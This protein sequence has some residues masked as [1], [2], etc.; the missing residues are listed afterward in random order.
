M[1]IPQ[2]KYLSEWEEK[3]IMHAPVPAVLFAESISED[4]NSNLWYDITG[5]QSLDVV[6]VE[7][8]LGYELLC[9]ILTTIYET[10]ENLEERLLA[11][12]NLLLIP[13]S[14]FL[15]CEREQV[16]LCYYPGGET[17]IEDAFLQLMEFLLEKL[18]HEDG[19]AVELAYGIY[20]QAAK[21]GWNLHALN[22]EILLR[23]EV[24]KEIEEETEKPLPAESVREDAI[25]E[26]QQ[27]KKAL[28]VEKHREMWL[29]RIKEFLY[30]RIPGKLHALIEKHT[31]GYHLQKVEERFVFEPEEEEKR[32][33]RP[34]VL[35]SDIEKPI[36]GVLRYEGTGECA[37]LKIE[38]EEYVIGSDSACAGYIPSPTVSRRHA[39]ITRTG[40]IYM[41]EDLNSS[42]GTYV[43][44]ELLN[45][46]TKV[47]IQKNEI[48]V[49]ADEKFRFI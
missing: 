27:G 36:E 48:I 30:A 17:R 47:S 8:K 29:H 20:N 15:D 5:K 11:A 9:Q 45:Y 23:Y 14:I 38:G 4:G 39:R 31:G 41:V 25:G 1:V 3:M 12:E 18:N 32:V 35:I 44:G 37:N 22:E 46:K 7:G 42:N 33:S 16:H 10:V 24:E 2:M 26:E 49:F 21:R 43:G 28:Y 13:E 19:Q 6:L 40:E 34:T